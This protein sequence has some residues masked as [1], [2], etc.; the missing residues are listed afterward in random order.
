VEE[1]TTFDGIVGVKVGFGGIIL[2][3]FT[4]PTLEIDFGKEGDFIPEFG[5]PEPDFASISF[6]SKVC[7][8]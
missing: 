6:K 3:V 1:V 7:P 5:K 2:G 8:S 4:F